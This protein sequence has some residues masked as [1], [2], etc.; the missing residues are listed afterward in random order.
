MEL[1]HARPKFDP[2]AGWPCAI[3]ACN[4]SGI[5][6]SRDC[7]AVRY[8]DGGSSPDTGRRTVA[9]C[10]SNSP[11][12]YDL[13]IA[14]A[15]W[16]LGNGGVS[17]RPGKLVPGLATEWK[18]MTRQTKWRFTRAKGVKLDGSDFNAD[19]VIWNLDKV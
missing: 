14:V 5:G 9:G 12:Y 15:C 7:C 8:F 16:D 19:A 1:G 2:L 3:G 11:A 4:F 18:G 6:E 13:T 10:L 17:A